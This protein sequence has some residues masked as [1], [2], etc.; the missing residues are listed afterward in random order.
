MLLYISL[1]FLILL[2]LILISPFCVAILLCNETQIAFVERQIFF[3]VF[4]LITFLL[5]FSYSCSSDDDDEL[6]HIK[7]LTQ[8]SFV[9]KINALKLLVQLQMPQFS[10][11]FCIHENDKLSLAIVKCWWFMKDQKITIAKQANED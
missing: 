7:I 2:L 10:Q 8:I 5:P 3:D 1:S 6:L 4:S 9:N 11:F